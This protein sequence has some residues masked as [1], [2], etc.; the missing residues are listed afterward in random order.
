[1]IKLCIG[2]LPGELLQGGTKNITLYIFIDNDRINLGGN[3]VGSVA[4]RLDAQG[5][6][7]CERG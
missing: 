1:M 7:S 5:K 6:K 3:F 2:E 4:Q